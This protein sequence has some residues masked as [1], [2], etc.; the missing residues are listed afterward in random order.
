MI[1][2]RVDG[3]EKIATG[4]VMRCLSIAEALRELGEE[5]TFILADQRPRD[6][7]EEKGFAVH[8]LDTLWD[9][10][11]GEC[12]TLAAYI[13]EQGVQKLVIDSYSVTRHYLSEIRKYTGLIYMDD[14][15]AFAY[16]VDMLINYGFLSSREAYAGNYKTVDSAP[17]F[18]IG[19]DY[20]PLRKE[21]QNVEFS[22]KKEVQDILI[23]TG[24]ADLYNIAG[25]VL[26]LALQDKTLAGLG[27]HVIAGRFNCN[28]EELREIAD[29]YENVTLYENVSNMSQCMKSCDIAVTAGGS[30]TYE[31]CAVGIPSVCLSMAAN[32][33]G[34]ESW[35]KEGIMLYAGDMETDAKACIQGVIRHLKTYMAS[36]FLRQ[37]KSNAMRKLVDGKGAWRLAKEII[38][39]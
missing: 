28:K 36:Y 34:I 29:R 37:E 13:Q 14:M 17:R 12:E 8:I 1:Y 19:C 4:H 23:T 5:S 20:I 11:D 9:D 39:L 27:F 31:L 2:F 25:N 7:I 16:P 38:D 26:A 15:N 33:R 22:L 6:L 35:E 3:N 30:T 18:L 32:Q 21:F 24:G 10:M